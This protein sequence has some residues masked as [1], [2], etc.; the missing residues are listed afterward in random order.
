MV[1]GGFKGRRVRLDA[2]GLYASLGQRLGQTRVVGE[3]GMT[4]LSSQLWSDPVPAGQQPGDFVAPPWLR[5]YTVD[6]ATGQPASPGLLRFVDLANRW[7]VLAIETMDMGIVD[8]ILL[9]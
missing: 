3:Y 8:P 4:E 7:S 2:P 6:P 5:V 9:L 1:T